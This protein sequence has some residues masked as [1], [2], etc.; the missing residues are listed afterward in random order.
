MT[1]HSPNSITASPGPQDD[2]ARFADSFCK[3]INSVVSQLHEHGE[4]SP[5]RISSQLWDLAAAVKHIAEQYT[6]DYFSHSPPAAG[7]TDSDDSLIL[8][9]VLQ[10]QHP[11]RTRNALSL[12]PHYPARLPDLHPLVLPL[13]VL[14][15]LWSN[16]WAL[17][18]LPSPLRCS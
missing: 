6:A 4:L 1:I 14:D 2:R 8:S 5:T 10:M 7:H 18:S 11:P 17:L 13:T 15:G 3:Q 12:A 9:P 16:H